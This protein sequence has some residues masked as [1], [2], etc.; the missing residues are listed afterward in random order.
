MKNITVN[1][2]T[3][4]PLWTGDAWG[5]N[6]TIRPSSIIGSLRFWFYVYCKSVNIPLEKKNQKE[7]LITNLNDY[8]KEY[9]RMEKTNESFESLLG[10]EINEKVGYNEAI[11]NVFQKINFPLILQIFGCTGWK[12]QIKIK[13]IKLKETNIS[14]EDI[15]F[16]FLYDKINTQTKNSFFWANKLLFNK[17]DNIK[18]FTDLTIEFSLNPIFENEFTEFLKFFQ[19]KIILVGGKKS[20]GFGFCLIRTNS[21]PQNINSTSLT[22]IYGFK[23]MTLDNIPEDKIILGFNFKHYQRL[24]EKKAFRE[25]NFGKQGKASN[26]FFSCKNKDTKNIYLVGF[27]ENDNIFNFLMNKYSQFNLNKEKH[28]D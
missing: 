6:N 18:L 3:L 4:T 15:D 10:K 16:Y 14:K 1:F 12:S 7:G 13:S 27:N 8:V 22:T 28:E 23:K 11:K 2:Q 9:N 19:D 24:N 26:F 21:E 20:F 5:E 25:K 17:N